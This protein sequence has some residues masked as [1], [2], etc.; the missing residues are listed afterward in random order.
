MSEE[1]L[2]KIYIATIPA[3][4]SVIS[5]FISFFLGQRSKAKSIKQEALKDR[6]NHFYVPYMKLLMNNWYGHIASGLLPREEKDQFYIL[7]T[8]NI[9]YLGKRSSAYLMS[10]I[11]GYTASNFDEDK[12]QHFEGGR[13]KFTPIFNKMTLLILKEAKGIARKLKLQPPSITASNS[14]FHRLEHEPLSNKDR[15]NCR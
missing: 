10:Y 7:V 13:E 15:L 5:I 8:E 9:H 14:F 3:L 4:I 2:E 11:E 6:Y 1:T 12:H